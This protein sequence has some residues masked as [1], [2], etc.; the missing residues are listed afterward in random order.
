LV[1]SNKISVCFWPCST[2]FDATQCP[3]WILVFW[4]KTIQ[5]KSS[6]VSDH[7]VPRSTPLTALP[8][9]HP[10]EYKLFK[11][12]LHF[13]LTLAELVPI[14]SL[15]SN[16][17]ITHYLSLL[18]SYRE[19]PYLSIDWFWPWISSS[20]CLFNQHRCRCINYPDIKS[21]TIRSVAF[22]SWCTMMILNK[23]F[24][25]QWESNSLSSIFHI[26]ETKPTRNDICV[27]WSSVGWLSE[28]PQC[29]GEKSCD[30]VLGYSNTLGIYSNDKSNLT[31]D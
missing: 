1:D 18:I 17:P 29:N 22:R 2:A 28:T 30:H 7:A 16:Q 11:Y 20:R 8:K 19:N 5:I 4:I 27:P 25:H 15:S 9:P 6:F 14:F 23:L 3:P 12:N 24:I 13:L 26:S 31:P 21:H 10:P